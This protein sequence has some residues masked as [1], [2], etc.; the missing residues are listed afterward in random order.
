M[1][2]LLKSMIC[3][4]G[5]GLI[6]L[7]TWWVYPPAALIILGAILLTDALIERKPER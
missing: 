1:R 4:L 5:T 2:S 6:V 7:G 3:L